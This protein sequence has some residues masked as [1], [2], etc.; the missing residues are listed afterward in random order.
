M[1]KKFSKSKVGQTVIAVLIAFVIKTL[2]NT[3]RWK[4][5]D[6]KYKLEALNETEPIIVVFWHER[7]AVMSK[8]WP[9]DKPLAMLQSPHSDGQLIAKAINML[10]FQTVWGSTN[11][12][13]AG[14]ITREP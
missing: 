12:N 11:R 4:T 9:L 7:I 8:I 13:A 14:A 1:I 6:H 2:S 3:I 5:F 10:G